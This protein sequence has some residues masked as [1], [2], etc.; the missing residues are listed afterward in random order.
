MGHF[1]EVCMVDNAQEL[2]ELVRQAKDHGYHIPL[3]PLWE[4]NVKTVLR[5][6]F[7]EALAYFSGFRTHIR[8]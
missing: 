2:A 5:P 1:G 6:S 8:G 7:S 4:S 3:N